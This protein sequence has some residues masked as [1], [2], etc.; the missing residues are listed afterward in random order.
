MTPDHASKWG[1]RYR[2]YASQKDKERLELPVHRIPAGEI[3]RLVS[4]QLAT[5]TEASWEGPS[6]SRELV[7]DYVEK[8]TVHSDRVEV[9]IAGTDEPVTIHASLIRCGGEVR[10]DAPSQDWIDARRDKSLIKLIV[11]AHQ[12]RAVIESPTIPSIDA[13]ADSLGLSQQYFCRLLRLAYLAPDITAAILDG[14]QPTHINRQFLARVNN[15]PMD[16]TGQREML[17]FA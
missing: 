11:R 4:H 5:K 7:L 13:A 1:K 16:W 2:Y 14:K 12:A 3:E 9:F 15:L 10:I 8:V 6:P 17:G